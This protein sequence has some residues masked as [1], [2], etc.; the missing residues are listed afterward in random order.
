M[1]VL[2]LVATPIGNLS[3]M[4]YRAVEVLQS[5]DYILCEDT[6]H[7]SVLLKHYDIKK[8]L[9]S[10]HKFNEAS[11][12]DEL[13]IDLHDGKS[14]ALI[15]DAGTPGIADPGTRLVEKAVEEGISVTSIPG[16]CAAVTALSCSGLNTELFQFVGFLPKKQQEL[17]NTL[18]EILQ[19]RGTTICYESPN[20][21][22]KTLEIIHELAAERKV[23]VGR[24]LT[25]KFEETIRGKAMDLISRFKEKAPKGE[26][27]LMISGKENESIDW[28]SLSLEEHV[29]LVEEDYGVS[30]KEAIKVVAQLRG[31]PKRD[32]YKETIQ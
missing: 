27:V 30:K 14:I 28:T 32:V 23:S 26:I 5:C 31:V 29:K 13:I 19:Y 7:S 8:P 25:K 3:D 12:E 2:Y 6:R 1:T 9:K 10:Y 16:A 11:R 20:R 4:T 18:R 24:E 21:L 22:I 15:S 17:S